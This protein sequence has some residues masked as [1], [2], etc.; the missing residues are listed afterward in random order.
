MGLLSAR[1]RSWQLVSIACLFILV[2]TSIS[3][4]GAV[5]PGTTCKKAGQTSTTNGIKYICV[6]SGKKLVWNKGVT[7]KKPAPTPATP[8]PAASP[9]PNVTSVP[10]TQS[11]IAFNNI[12][13]YYNESP[14]VKYELIKVTHPSVSQ[15]SVDRII[16]RYEKV[17]KFFR[18]SFAVKKVYVIVGN[19]DQLLWT[20]QQLELAT[21]YK[22]DEWYANFTLGMPERRCSTY[23]AGSYGINKSGHFM[24]SFTL[25]PADCPSEEPQDGNYRTTIEHELV[26]ASQSAVTN[27]QIQLL[28]CWF[29]EGQA[30]YYGSVLGNPTSYTSMKSSLS[31]QTRFSRS[32]DPKQR[33]KQ[34]DEK[35][36]NFKCGN[37]GGYALGALAVQQMVI[38]YSHQ[39]IMDFSKDVGMTSNWRTSFANI[40]GESFDAFVDNMADQDLVTNL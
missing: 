9:T 30:S 6:K 14:A 3:A 37:D 31:F 36:D 10:L 19:N 38:K 23:N 22:F 32:V 28:P 25:Y 8:S 35:Y 33:L 2:T 27:N 21:G 17:L 34:L 20:K 18:D 26:H 15:A 39:K 29:K 1:S 24:Q 7:I 4:Y 12:V 5:K 16:S 13:S 40:F 11:E